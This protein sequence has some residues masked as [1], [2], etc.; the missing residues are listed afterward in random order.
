MQCAVW[1][2]RIPSTTHETKTGGHYL[3]ADGVTTLP[4]VADVLSR[5][6]ENSCK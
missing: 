3:D 1:E 5:M 4:L 6:M 2:E